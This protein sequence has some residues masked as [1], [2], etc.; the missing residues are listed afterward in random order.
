MDY[1]IKFF[2]PLVYSTY[3]QFIE[4]N[5]L[6]NE[7]TTHSNDNESVNL[8]NRSV[9]LNF[10]QKIS[11]VL[12]GILNIFLWILI[13]PIIIIVILVLLVFFL[14][15]ICCLISSTILIYSGR[16]SGAAIRSAVLLISLVKILFLIFS[17]FVSMR[18]SP[19]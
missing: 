3:Q 15:L 14:I 16:F 19:V 5:R 8:I 6:I 18:P 1:F 17:S 11:L 9:D 10:E 13:S 7:T 12:I 4:D 2:L